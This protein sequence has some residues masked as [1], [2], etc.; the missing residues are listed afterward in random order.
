MEGQPQSRGYSWAQM[1]FPLGADDPN[2]SLLQSHSL[3][4]LLLE[5]LLR[6]LQG[7]LGQ[8]IIWE[9]SNHLSHSAKGYKERMAQENR[10]CSFRLLR[11][12]NLKSVTIKSEDGQSSTGS[13]WRHNHNSPAKV[14]AFSPSNSSLRL[15]NKLVINNFIY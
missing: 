11:F 8:K 7:E 14:L 3:L 1:C 2:I 13:L 12:L 4:P 5:S 15:L 9:K 6:R 10:R